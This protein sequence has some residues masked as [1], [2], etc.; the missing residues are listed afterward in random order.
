[1]LPSYADPGSP[2]FAPMG[3]KQA[4]ALG[5]KEYASPYRCRKC[6]THLR[7]TRANTCVFCLE[8]QRREREALIQRGRREVMDSARAQVLR[9]LAAAE[10][11]QAKEAEK[12]QKEAARQEAKEAAERERKRAQREARRAER[13]SKAAEAAPEPAPK[14]SPQPHAQ[15]AP[16][17]QDVPPWEVGGT[18]P[19]AHLPCSAED[20]APWD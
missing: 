10:R 14:G 15:E 9:E 7:R 11:R 6:Y 17:G 19:A 1:M 18:P 13:L 16:G 20:T 3:R 2:D 4:L 5:L 12:A 8:L